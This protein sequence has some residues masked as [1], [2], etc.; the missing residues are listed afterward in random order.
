MGVLFGITLL[1]LPKLGYI[2]IGL[3]VAVIVSLLLQN[4]IYYLT[5]TLTAFYIT[6]GVVGVIMCGISLMAFK[7]Y[8]IMSTSF[9]SAFW[10][11]RP[12]GF[13][14]SSY[15]NEFLSG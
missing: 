11:V 8:I 2:N 14:L 15:P 13:F 9:I 6:F 10:L 3:W 4:S 12:L 1:T 7:N 5:G